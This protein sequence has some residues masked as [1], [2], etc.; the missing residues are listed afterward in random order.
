MMHFNEPSSRDGSGYDFSSKVEEGQ[1]LRLKNDRHHQ[2]PSQKSMLILDARLKGA[3]D[4][5]TCT[6][7]SSPIGWSAPIEVDVHTTS[8]EELVVRRVLDPPT[9]LRPRPLRLSNAFRRTRA[10]PPCI[11]HRVRKD[12]SCRLRCLLSPRKCGLDRRE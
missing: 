6:A 12:A 10:P 1:F 3:V 7:F 8:Y 9:K 11:T 5:T 2:S 4:V